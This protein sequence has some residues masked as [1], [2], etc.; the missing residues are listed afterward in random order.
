VGALYLYGVTRPR[1]LPARLGERGIFLVEDDGRAAIVSELDAAPVQANRR[2]LLAHADTVEDLHE[3]AVVLPTRFGTVLDD[4]DAARELLALPE[5]EEL[6]ERHREHSEMTLKGTY[7]QAV[8]AE[9]AHPLAPLR[10]AY[11]QAPT[12]AAGVALGEA[13]TEALADRRARDLDRVMGRVAPHVVDVVVSKPLGELGALD[14]AL[15]VRRDAVAP[16]ETALGEV[17]A[18]L[19]PPLHLRLVGPLPPYSFVSLD[20]PVP[21]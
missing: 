11:R 16:L 8:L 20:V 7:E 21:A 1:E 18:A 19:S 12:M 9:V 5:L 10:E 13:V 17:A 6:L 14:V 2:N 4:H 3:Q 15:L